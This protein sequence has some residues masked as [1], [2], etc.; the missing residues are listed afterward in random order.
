[1]KLKSTF[2]LLLLT[3]L[4]SVGPFASAGDDNRRLE[5]IA[6]LEKSN[7]F[8]TLKLAVV[9]KIIDL[10]NVTGARMSDERVVAY[11]KE[12]YPKHRSCFTCGMSVL[13]PQGYREIGALQKGDPIMSWDTANHY[14]VVNTIVEVHESEEEFGILRTTG[15]GAIEVTPSHPFYIPKEDVYV[16]ISDI[17][18]GVGLLTVDKFGCATW[19]SAKDNYT[20]GGVGRVRN[21]SLSHEPLNF[22]VNGILVHNIK[23]GL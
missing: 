14:F 12:E 18:K 9:D 21:L 15:T 16:P 3:I 8:P 2:S 6:I 17:P 13:T 23:G 5:V 22:I 7:R 4:L 10:E 11:A 1:M 19:L 20:A